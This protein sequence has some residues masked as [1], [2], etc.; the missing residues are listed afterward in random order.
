[1]RVAINEATC[2]ISKGP[3]AALLIIDDRLSYIAHNQPSESSKPFSNHAEILVLKQYLADSKKHSSNHHQLTLVSTCEPCVTCFS[4]ALS[5]GVKNFVYGSDIETAI[6]NYS[7][8]LYFKIQNMSQKYKLSIFPN[9]LKAQCDDLFT[10]FTKRHS[11]IVSSG[12]AE[13]KF[14]MNQALEIGKKGMIEKQELPIGV[15]LVADDQ[16]LSQSS[17]M[18][19]TLHSPITHGDFFSLFLAKREFY[20]K[21]CPRPLVL[22]STLEPH[23]LGFGAAIKCGVD[24]IVYGLKAYPDGGSNYLT[25]LSYVSERVPMIIEGVCADK[26]YLLLKKFL[27]NYPKDRVGY[28]YALQL[29][30]QYENLHP[31][32]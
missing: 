17:T 7:G 8:D 24:K 12:S 15:I 32:K 6:Q 9:V 31:K 22:Y 27:K 26:Q 11:V 2:N 30:T 10:Q 14:W 29:T 23:L 3:Y 16:I 28:N 1:M 13:E 5:I 25:D 19:Y 4:F 20:R 21:D 18:T